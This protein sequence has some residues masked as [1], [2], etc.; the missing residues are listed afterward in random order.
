MKTI[1]S[2]VLIIFLCNLT[3]AQDNSKYGDNSYVRVRTVA[4]DNIIQMKQSVLLVRL[5]TKKASIQA[6]RDIGKNEDADKIESRQRL[7]NLRIVSAF[8]RHFN[9]CPV[10]FF[11]SE[12]SQN[13]IDKQFDKVLFIND[14]LVEDPSIK[15][16][17]S[18]F[19]ISE[20]A[21]HQPDTAMYYSGSTYR[22]DGSDNPEP[23]KKYYGGTE[24]QIEG[25]L[26]E[27]QVFVQLSDPFPNFIKSGIFNSKEMANKCVTKLNDRLHNFYNAQ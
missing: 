1:L 7:E 22:A 10:Y 18:S 12:Y 6:L 20:F 8:R 25:L 19:Y 23:V 17:L 15:P 14:S 4:K 27:N 11:Y 13:I 21:N 5:H 2:A 3:F 26:V 16:D 24:L 9:F